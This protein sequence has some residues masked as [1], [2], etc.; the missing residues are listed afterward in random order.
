MSVRE[1]EESTFSN[2]DQW[3]YYLLRYETLGKGADW[4]QGR[5]IKSL[6]PHSKFEIVKLS[7]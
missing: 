6:V 3:C 1:R 4:K 7:G 2:Q 5:R